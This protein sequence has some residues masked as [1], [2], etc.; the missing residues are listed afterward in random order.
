L[1]F[2]D[3]HDVSLGAGQFSPKCNK[4]VAANWHWTHQ[5]RNVSCCNAPNLWLPY[6]S[7]LAWNHFS[8]ESRFNRQLA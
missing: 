4:Q 1:V 3:F 7:H 5:L 6:S 2:V 8:L